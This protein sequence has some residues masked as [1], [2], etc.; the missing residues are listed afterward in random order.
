MRERKHE[1][2][3]DTDA[4]HHY[5]TAQKW[6]AFLIASFNHSQGDGALQELMFEYLHRVHPEMS[7]SD[8]QKEA[9]QEDAHHFVSRVFSQPGRAGHVGHILV[10]PEQV[11]VRLQ[12]L[13]D[14][15]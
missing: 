6:L 2:D 14:T 1:F 13:W 4:E 3:D 11:S 9:L 15:L 7:L 10:D 5:F 8:E 12:S